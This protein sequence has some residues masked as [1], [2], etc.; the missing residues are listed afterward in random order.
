MPYR[1]NSRAQFGICLPSLSAEPDGVQLHRIQTAT[2]AASHPST[3]S[4][5]RARGYSLFGFDK[6]S[7]NGNLRES[8]KEQ[9][10]PQPS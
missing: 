3:M 5:T 10:T 8:I 1:A 7:P 2:P 6:L 9:F 4:E